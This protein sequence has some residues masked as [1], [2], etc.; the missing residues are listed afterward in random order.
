MA[1]RPCIVFPGGGIYFWWQAGA[2]K[3]LQQSIEMDE[4]CYVGASAGSISAVFAAC[5][6][7]MDEAFNSAARLA[8]ENGLWD[9]REGF[10]GIWGPLIGE[11]R[12]ECEGA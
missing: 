4:Y 5:N 11:E 1:S 3:A 2:V 6:V 9:R 12:F 8:D 10:A 7:D